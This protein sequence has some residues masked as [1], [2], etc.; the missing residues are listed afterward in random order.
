MY[1]YVLRVCVCMYVC[2]CAHM[3]VCVFMYV[4]VC[5]YVAGSWRK[6]EDS[7][8]STEVGVTGRFYSKLP[9]LGTENCCLLEQ[10]EQLH[11]LSGPSLVF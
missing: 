3:C 10:K 5:V 11:H 4:C 2:V 7:R 8:E 9:D 6:P 1:V